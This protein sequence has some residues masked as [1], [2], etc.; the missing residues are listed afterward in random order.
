MDS[1]VIFGCNGVLV[2]AEMTIARVRAAALA[3]IGI[4]M[5]APAIAERFAGQSTQDM[6]MALERENGVPLQA[7][8]IEQID[9]QAE[10]RIAREARAVEGAR[11]AV[12]AT[13]PRC[14]C[15]HLS[16]AHLDLLLMASGLARSIDG[17]SVSLDDAEGAMP[18]P[19]PDLYLHAA[20]SM[21]AEPE[22]CFVVEGR[23][24]AIAAAIAAGMRAIGFSGGSHSFPG[25]AD[26]LTD[27]G[28]ETV[29]SR[30]RDF[31]PVLC[32]LKEWRD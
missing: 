8:L 24:E 20:A 12:E 26:L 30:W 18:A 22:Q 3:G 7:S 13:A 31:A 15:A 17:R 1:L 9:R 2:D 10:K 28:A 11:N 32:A 5:E 27:A 21:G 23:A 25:H 16:R 29:I 19:A 14:V 4:A 6:L